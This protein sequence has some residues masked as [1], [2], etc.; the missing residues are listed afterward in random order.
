[1]EKME[2]AVSLE[3]LRPYV[4]RVGFGDGTS[5]EIDIEPEHW[6]AVFEPLRDP[7]LFAQA[8]LDPTFGSVY[9]S[10]GADLAPEFL[11]FGDEGPPAGF[12][13]PETVEEEV[14][15]VSARRR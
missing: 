5:R 6:G 1:M 2:K 8:S 3:V 14:V 10:T 11:Y 12:Y 13:E 15:Q 7:A 9:W 4:I